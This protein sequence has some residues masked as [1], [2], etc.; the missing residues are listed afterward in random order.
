MTYPVEA[1]YVYHTGEAFRMPKGDQ[2]KYNY[3]HTCK[4][5]ECYS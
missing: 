2:L 5:N 3:I 1:S 4:F